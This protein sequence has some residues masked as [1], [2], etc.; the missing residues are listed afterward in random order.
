MT[1]PIKGTPNQ[2]FTAGW[3]GDLGQ[4]AKQIISPFFAGWYGENRNNDRYTQKTENV[5][6]VCGIH[7]NKH[8]SSV[9]YTKFSVLPNYLTQKCSSLY[10][11][12]RE[13]MQV[14]S[15]ESVNKFGIPIEYY[16]IDGYELPDATGIDAVFGETSKKT[17]MAVW[18]NVMVWYPF[19]RESRT[20]SKFGI[21]AADQLTVHIPKASFEHITGGRYPQTGD[22]FREITTNRLFE[23]TDREEGEPEFAFFQSR[24]YMW[25]LKAVPYMRQE[26]LF[27]TN[28]TSNSY[29]AGV[30]PKADKL[31]I[32]NDVDVKVEPLK[33]V[34]KANEKSQ[35]NPF[36]NF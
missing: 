8:T 5:F 36:A 32:T 6:F 17:V 16:W 19:R 14:L 15:Q 25:E 1:V 26:A 7:K 13:L 33:Y 20:W 24:Q 18:S 2:I 23:I 21:G 9:D 35:S 34:P 4:K 10:N 27:F 28:E 12:D 22:I 11:G 30:L 3:F 29:L 31:D